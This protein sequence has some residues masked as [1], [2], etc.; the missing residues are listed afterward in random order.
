MWR[1]FSDTARGTAG[2]GLWSNTAHKQHASLAHIS[3]SWR[4]YP[5]VE[6]ALTGPIMSL[7]SYI[8]QREVLSSSRRQENM[9][10]LFSVR[11][12][13]SVTSSNHVT[14]C[15]LGVMFVPTQHPIFTPDPDNR[16]CN[17]IV[18][19]CLQVSGVSSAIWKERAKPTPHQTPG[20]I[21]NIYLCWLSLRCFCMCRASLV[22]KV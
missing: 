6:G 14:Y 3:H 15:V 18:F 22:F 21:Q 1:I 4:F 7:P 17:Y 19:C 20:A 5:V 9:P 13:L 12:T 16:W 8:S 2:V 11:V 10:R